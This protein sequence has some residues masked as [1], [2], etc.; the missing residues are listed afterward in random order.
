MK[1]WSEDI[2]LSKY[3]WDFGDGITDSGNNITHNYFV[4]GD[5]YFNVILKVLN[6]DGCMES[7]TKKVY[8]SIDRI[9]NIFT[10]NGDGDN[11]VFLKGSNIQ[12]YNSNGILLY[13]GINGWDG[14]YKGKAVA[15]DTYYY[16][17]VTFKEKGTESIAGFVTVLR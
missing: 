17:K 9:P 1:F 12:I 15:N 3:F 14:S 11:D 6:P 10:P 5:G 2:Y 13:E 16:V 7:T 4:N 8:Y